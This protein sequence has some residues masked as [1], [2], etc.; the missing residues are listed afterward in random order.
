[1]RLRI[2]FIRSSRLESRQTEKLP[3]RTEAIFVFKNFSISKISP[4]IVNIRL[5][6]VATFRSQ[7][8]KKILH[9]ENLQIAKGI[10]K[11]NEADGGRKVKV[12]NNFSI[13]ICISL[14]PEVP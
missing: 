11:Q 12:S 3:R 7:E 2:N 8:K 14:F 13:T 1:M 9:H 4:V 10:Q 6:S 5:V